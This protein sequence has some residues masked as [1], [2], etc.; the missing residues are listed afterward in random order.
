MWSML[1]VFRH[2]EVAHS[3]WIA[4]YVIRPLCIQTH[5]DNTHSRR[6]VLLL[7]IVE[8]HTHI[9][10]F[11]VEIARVLYWN[12][13]IVSLI[14]GVALACCTYS[15]RSDTDRYHPMKLYPLVDSFQVY[16]IDEEGKIT[17][18]PE[19]I[20]NILTFN[21]YWILLWVTHTYHVYLIA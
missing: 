5:N 8:C 9:K 14:E 4:V 13:F 21:K 10:H 3:Q 19:N 12:A 11:G 16:Y 18:L 17:R 1:C 6:I 20:R 15:V 7:S 2:T